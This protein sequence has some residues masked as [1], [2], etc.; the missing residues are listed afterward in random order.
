MSHTPLSALEQRDEFIA[1]HIGPD[2]A[3]T[4]AML[5]AVGAS[6]LD[7][8]IG[9]TVSAAIRLAQPLPLPGPLRE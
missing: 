3:E 6:S 2:A 7:E 5:A 9:Q 1:R 8:L 4:A